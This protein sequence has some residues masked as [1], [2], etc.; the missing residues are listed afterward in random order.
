MKKNIFFN[1]I[2]LAITIALITP[3]Q[4]MGS[5]RGNNLTA[6]IQN[7]ID[8]L[9][10]AQP[11]PGEINSPAL[12]AEQS[13]NLTSLMQDA[14]QLDAFVAT[15]PA[16]Q[17]TEWAHKQVALL[18]SAQPLLKEIITTNITRTWQQHGKNLAQASLN[19]LLAGISTA[20]ISLVVQGLKIGTGNLVS[21]DTNTLLVTGL[22]S[23]ANA[24]IM[25]LSNSYGLA[26]A[27]S[28]AL[29]EALITPCLASNSLAITMP[30]IKGPI[31]SWITGEAFITAKNMVENGIS[32]MLSNINLNQML[33][34]T[35][36]KQI[37]QP[38][39][40]LVQAALPNIQAMTKN[41]KI[42]SVLIEIGWIVVQSAAVGGLLYMAGFGY[43]GTATASVNSAVLTGAAQGTLAAL[44]TLGGK[45]SPGAIITIASA[46]LAQQALSIAGGTP[47]AAATAV[48]QATITEVSNI[49]LDESKKQGGLLQ[50][51]NAGK[52]LLGQTMLSRWESTFELISETW[53]FIKGLGQMPTDI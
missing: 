18:K 31:T 21:L 13:K 20:A 44:A 16:Q 11:K 46:P 15:L 32:P 22:T 37:G 42:A 39:N 35:W 27:S 28:G 47:Q 51:L 25:T 34:P 50:T 36:S 9:K 45:V 2:S 26:Y 23:T 3:L 1:F 19:I 41:Q 6:N 52:K 7:K 53:G 17:Q 49:F 14:Q 33:L 43:T 29:S 30:S 8:K 4:S 24:I 48:L 38:S 10:A 12:Q 5:E 40:E